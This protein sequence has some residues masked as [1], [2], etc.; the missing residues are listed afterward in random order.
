MAWRRVAD[1]PDPPETLP[2]LYGVAA[3]VIANQRRTI[4]RKT[5]LDS[6]LL[7]LGVAPGPDPSVMVVRRE[8]D[9]EIE[10]AVRSLNNKDTEIVML[11][12][13]EELPRQT[14]A[15]MLGMTKAAVDQRILRS[16]RRLARKLG[17][18]PQTQIRT[19]TIAKE[20]AHD[21]RSS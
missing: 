21:H 7:N 5:K 18:L 11:Y 16:Y 15:D 14:I 6:K 1:V 19:S 12:A 10:A 13:W 9:Q 2:Y 8:Q 17:S 4:R 3:N 20:E